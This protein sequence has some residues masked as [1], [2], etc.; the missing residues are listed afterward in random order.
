MKRVCKAPGCGFA[1]IG[2]LKVMSADVRVAHTFG[3]CIVHKDEITSDA[4]SA[5]EVSTVEWIRLPLDHWANDGA[6]A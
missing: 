2:L 6:A 1:S 5:P 3:L 4:L